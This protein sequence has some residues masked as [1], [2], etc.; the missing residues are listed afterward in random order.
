MEICQAAPFCTCSHRPAC[1]KETAVHT[2]GRKEMGLFV[3]QEIWA[4]EF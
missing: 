3:L 2:H 1:E 4:D